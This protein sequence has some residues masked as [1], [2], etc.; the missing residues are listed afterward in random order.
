MNKRRFVE[1]HHCEIGDEYNAKYHVS[2]RWCYDN[3]Y[4]VYLFCLQNRGIGD[5]IEGEVKTRK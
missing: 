4:E 5:C 2:C 3:D 1:L